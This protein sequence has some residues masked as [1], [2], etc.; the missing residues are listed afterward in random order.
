[1]PSLDAEQNNIDVGDLC[2]VVGCLRRLNDCVSGGSFDAQAAMLYRSEMLTTRDE[3]YLLTR[4]CQ[5]CAKVATRASC[6]KNNKS[7]H[8]L[9][10]ATSNARYKLHP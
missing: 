9:Y 7:H 1:L 8:G 4:Q 3:H 2:W 5:L 10:W 6:T